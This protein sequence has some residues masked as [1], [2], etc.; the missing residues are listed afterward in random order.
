MRFL[1]IPR[2]MPKVY[3]VLF[4]AGAAGVRQKCGHSGGLHAGTVLVAH[5]PLC[6]GGVNM[7]PC[8]NCWLQYSSYCMGCKFW[9]TGIG[10]EG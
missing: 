4:S 3:K 5:G 7:A 2:P 9:A 6:K 10:L 1:W 8:N